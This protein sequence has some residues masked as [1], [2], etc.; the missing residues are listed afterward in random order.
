MAYLLWLEVIKWFKCD[1]T[2]NMRY[3]DETK[4]FWKLG[5][6]LFGGRF[7]SFMSGFKNNNQVLMNTTNRGCYDPAKSEIN[8]AVPDQ[9]VLRT[10]NTYSLEL[11]KG[12]TK[13]G[14]AHQVMNVF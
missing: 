14:I 2:T 4:K 1:T 10:Y 5:Y 6:R 9:K 11:G 7:I 3:I 12:V 13:P 8:W